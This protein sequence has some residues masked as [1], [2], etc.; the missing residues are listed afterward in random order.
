M[1]DKR[2]TKNELGF[3]VKGKKCL[4]NSFL[5]LSFNANVFPL[6]DREQGSCL[7]ENVIWQES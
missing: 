3:L 5:F 6:L 7:V 4:A 1:S 2:L